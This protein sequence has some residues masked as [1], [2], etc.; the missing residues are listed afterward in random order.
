MPTAEHL[1]A[2]TDIFPWSDTFATGIEVIDAQHH[3]LVDLL[4][5]LAGH[6]AFGS[7]ELIL[8]AVFDELADYAVYHFQTEEGVW[9]RHL[10]QDSLVLAHHQTHREFVA[11]VGQARLKLSQMSS[12]ATV[13]EMVSFLTHWLAFH[14]L[15]DDTHMAKLV[16]AVQSGCSMDQAKAQATAQMKSA[17]HVL[18]T[19]VLSMYDNLSMR[20][21]ALLREVS[22]R[23]RAE[24]KLRLSSNIIESST[25]GIFITDTQGLVIDVNPAFCLELQRTHATLLGQSIVSLMPSL[26]GTEPGQTAWQAC[27]DAGHWAGELSMRKPDGELE[28]I[29]L[30][31]TRVLDETLQVQHVVGM[32]SSISQ[33]VARHQALE[34]AANH[35]VLTGLPNRRLLTDRLAQALQHSKRNRTPLAVCYLDLDG[36]KPIN[37]R[38]GHAAGDEVLR[39]VAQ[40]MQH[41]LRGADTVARMGGDEFVLLLGDAGGMDE[42]THRLHQM[43]SELTEPIETHAQQVRVGISMGLTL[44]PADPASADDLLRHADQMLYAAKADGK[45][46]L[47][48]YASSAG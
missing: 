19:T 3:K 7:D 12:D 46:C 27:T 6:M 45:G 33:L 17:A 2:Q 28:T 4:N 37:D 13:E 24:E 40:R 15:E 48:V 20:T 23:R 36:F 5:K 31:L 30:K 34:N 22:Q 18:I 10:G 26:L 47:R 32:I 21:L 8:T 16:L 42:V 14:I 44:F 39:V 25:D 29:W 38:L 1:I 41:A 11:Q 43:M 9:A 35:D